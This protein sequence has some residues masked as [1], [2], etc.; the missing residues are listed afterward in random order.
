M[1]DRRFFI[2]LLD[3]AIKHAVIILQVILVREDV[4]QFNLA[5]ILA[6]VVL[7]VVL[8]KGKVEYR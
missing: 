3:D 5:H 6:L 2:F 1:N 7:V 4:L 8:V